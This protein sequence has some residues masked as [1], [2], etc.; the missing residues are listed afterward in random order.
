MLVLD[1]HYGSPT[2]PFFNAWLRS[3]WMIDINWSAQAFPFA[4]WRDWI[5]FPFSLI[6]EGTHHLQLSFRSVRLAL[7]WCCILVSACLALSSVPWTG[8]SGRRLRPVA[9]TLLPS[10]LW[11]YLYFGLS[12]VF[13]A[14]FYGDYRYFIPSEML[15]PVIVVLTIGQLSPRRAVQAG[16][17][18]VAALG[19]VH[20]ES[21]GSWGR[22]TLKTGTYFGVRDLRHTISKD[23]M[24]V[25]TGLQG[26]AFL[27][28]FFDQ[29]IRFVRL[30]SNYT[31]LQSEEYARQLSKTVAEHRGPR[32][33]LTTA[34]VLAESGNITRRYGLQLNKD[35]CQPIE[36]IYGLQIVLCQLVPE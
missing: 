26:T 1:A 29:N 33:L 24:V 10:E 19:M 32:A 17:V 23:T 35:S 22:G 34:D 4:D 9:G 27:I 36:S 12:Y 14:K 16:I 6:R 7:A 2:L 15:T 13:W 21:V 30:E 8:L 31:G 18:A 5:V 25:M 20:F 28:P 11:L 3:P